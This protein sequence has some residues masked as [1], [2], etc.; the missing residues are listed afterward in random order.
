MRI[1][2]LRGPVGEYFNAFQNTRRA[3]IVPNH[4]VMTKQRVLVGAAP[5]RY[6]RVSAGNAAHAGSAFN[7]GKDRYET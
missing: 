2:A 6:R 5:L 7:D 1:V 4:R 3:P